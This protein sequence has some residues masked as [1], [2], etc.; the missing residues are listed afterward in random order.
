M[1]SILMANSIILP[2]LKHPLSLGL[3][4]M[5]QTTIVSMLI[6]M[7]SLSSWF[8]FI[9]FITIISGLMIMFMYMLSIASNE[10]FNLKIKILLFYVMMLSS[11]KLL[12]YDKTIEI[13]LNFKNM[14]FNMMEN[15]EI[16]TTSKFF[17]LN[18]SNIT[19]LMMIIL[20]ITMISVSKISNSFEGPLKKTYV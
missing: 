17:N 19:I 7:Q 11:I 3:I 8:S 10:K 9:L 18:K 16:K 1:Y 5:I 13:I 6:S 15:E 14:K 4:L 20:L 12:N 2:F